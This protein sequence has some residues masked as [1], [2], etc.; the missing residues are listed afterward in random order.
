MQSGFRLAAA[1]AIVATASLV[2]RAN[3][4][5]SQAS[6]VQLQLANLLYSEG[7]YLDALDAY[8][9]ALKAAASDSARASR[10]GV[11]NAALRVAEFD[12][13]R[14]EAETLVKTTPSAPD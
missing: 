8:K 9:E 4:P 2:I 14:Q 10:I 13:A 5:S 3:V 6:E 7:R 12:L 1:S 11:I